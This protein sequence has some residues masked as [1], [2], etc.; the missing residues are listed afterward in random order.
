[1]S[2]G[3][4]SKPSNESFDPSAGGGKTMKFSA[5]SLTAAIPS[6][7]T[8]S[9]SVIENNSIGAS[10]TESAAGNSKSVVAEK[11]GDEAAGARPETKEERR[12]RRELKRKLKQ[13]KREEKERKRL[14]KERKA[15]KKWQREAAAAAA[16]TEAAA[17]TTAA[18]G[19]VA[20]KASSSSSSATASAK[21]SP[22][23]SKPPTKRSAKVAHKTNKQKWSELELKGSARRIQKE[24]ADIS[25]NPPANISAGPKGNNLYEWVATMMGYVKVVKG[26]G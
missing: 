17:A 13:E 14:K 7:N 5:S 26:I 18:A 25:E 12:K 9:N 23:S 16:A 15:A 11:G 4:T 19:E 24:L 3:E 10:A 22:A 8:K 21:L 2:T 6:T 20:A 1:M